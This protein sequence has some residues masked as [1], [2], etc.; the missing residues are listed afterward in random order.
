MFSTN[1]GFTVNLLDTDCSPVKLLT[2][3][4]K[5]QRGISTEH[6]YVAIPDGQTFTIQCVNTRDVTANAQIKFEGRFVGCFHISANSAIII[7]RDSKEDKAFVCHAEKS[8]GGQTAGVVVGRNENG[9]IEIDVVFAKPVQQIRYKGS[10]QRLRSK[11]GDSPTYH[12]KGL[13]MQAKSK[14]GQPAQALPLPAQQSEV[15]GEPSVANSDQKASD[16]RYVAA[17][18]GLGGKTGQVFTIVESIKDIDP[19]Q[20]RSLVLRVL[21]TMTSEPPA[22]QAVNSVAIAKLPPRINDQ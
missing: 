7:K 2:D 14:S 20:T 21:A 17:G 16:S 3:V 8:S 11:G 10:D 22:P 18:L 15:P 6:Q 13:S 9:I 19:A 1:N 12:S 5:K 4:E